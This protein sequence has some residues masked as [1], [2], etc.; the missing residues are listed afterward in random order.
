MDQ[1]A[2]VI[3]RS[4]ADLGD[5]LTALPFER[6]RICV[7]G[8]S[9]TMPLYGK[10]VMEAAGKCFKT[11]EQY[12]FPAGEEYKT[13]DSIRELLRFLIEHH[14]DRHDCLLALGGGVTGDMTGF[15]AAIYLRGIPVIQLPTTLLAQIDSSI[16][17]KTGVDFDG[18]KNMVGAFHMPALV[19]TNSSAL[20][21]LPADQFVSGMGEVIKS[22]LLG[23]AELYV[24]LKD[25]ADEVN[26]G[27]EAA[28]EFMIRR[29]AAIKVGIVR[30]DPEEH[31]ERALL[32]FGHTIGHAV[33]KYLAFRMQHGCCVA[34]GLIAASKISAD[35]GLITEEEL[36]DIEKTCDLYGLPLKA[37]GIDAQEV[38]HFT[39]SDKKMKNGQIRF[40]LLKRPGEAFYT[41]DVTDEEILN[42]I[43]YITA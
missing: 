14:F 23:D 10:A 15:A 6:N 30:R 18:F 40:V 4:F 11:V 20:K 24:W 35:R 26:A 22:A 12:T 33:E 37:D 38:L 21:T 7:V 29:T 41:D 13:L 19:Y 3:S 5:A 34:L 42:G 25:H 36:H 16:G 2:P 27:N 8:D 9:H 1:L 28:L 17:G 39:K 32:N 43:R 31:G